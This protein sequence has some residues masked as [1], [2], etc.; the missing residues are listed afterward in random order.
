METFLSPFD[1][2]EQEQ[3]VDFF[4]FL[5][6]SCFLF[7]WIFF[8]ATLETSTHA[9]SLKQPCPNQL[10]LFFF[11]FGRNNQLTLEL[12]AGD[13]LLITTLT[14]CVVFMGKKTKKNSQTLSFCSMFIWN[15]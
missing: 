12:P 6:C 11:F 5:V 3:E 15:T 1:R 9:P 10:A 7:L 4:F 2:R 14:A 13:F 8:P